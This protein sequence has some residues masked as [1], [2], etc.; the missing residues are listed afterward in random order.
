MS[1]SVWAATRLSEAKTAVR[2]SHF[3]V[4]DTYVYTGQV[5]FSRIW[6]T[7]R[8]S[9]T[10]IVRRSPGGVESVN[11]K[12]P[13]VTGVFICV[14]QLSKELHALLSGVT[15]LAQHLLHLLQVTWTVRKYP[16]SGK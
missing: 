14:F 1:S 15:A 5:A 7:C 11:E 6:L 2:C 12:T 4:L 16:R 13:L 8:L 3:T 10:H 9:G